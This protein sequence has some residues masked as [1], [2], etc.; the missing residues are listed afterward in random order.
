MPFNF[1]IFTHKS[2]LGLLLNSNHD[3]FHEESYRIRPE[4]AKKPLTICLWLK[5]TY[6]LPD[7]LIPYKSAINVTSFLIN[8]G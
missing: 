4:C 1:D 3:R 8:T 7:I 6:Y 5:G 2:L